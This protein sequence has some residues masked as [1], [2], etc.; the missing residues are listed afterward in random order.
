MSEQVH[1]VNI[2]LLDN[3]KFTEA[4]YTLERAEGAYIATMCRI[5]VMH[6]LSK[7]PQMREPN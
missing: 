1:C 5:E 4:A 6:Q 3:E 2:Q 7:C